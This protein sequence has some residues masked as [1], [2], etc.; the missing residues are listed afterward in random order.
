MNILKR[1]PDDLQEKIYKI[2]HHD[3]MRKM[4]RELWNNLKEHQQEYYIS[5]KYDSESASY[6]IYTENDKLQHPDEIAI[7]G[8]C[9]VFQGQDDMWNTSDYVGDVLENPSYGDILLEADN[10]IKITEDNHHIFLEGFDI[11][12][13]TDCEI[14]IIELCMGS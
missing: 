2:I 1:L 6:C 13:Y 9:V 5:T 11:V 3:F 8:K 12:S 14:A 7:Y 10:A 4:K